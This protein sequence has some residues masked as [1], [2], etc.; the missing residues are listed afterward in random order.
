[1]KLF[2]CYN[3]DV[4]TPIPIP[5]SPN[6]NEFVMGPSSHKLANF[7]GLLSFPL[8]LSVNFES[9][10]R[11]VTIKPAIN[12]SLLGTNRKVCNGNWIGSFQSCIVIFVYYFIWIMRHMHKWDKAK[13]FDFRFHIRFLTIRELIP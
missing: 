6:E 11:L 9:Y 5:S 12:W 8:N 10:Q 13:S 2:V 4:N 1:M 7:S 3:L